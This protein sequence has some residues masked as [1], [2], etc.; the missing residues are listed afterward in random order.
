MTGE[1]EER[2]EDLQ[3]ESDTMEAQKGTIESKR[4]ELNQILAEAVS[5]GDLR[6]VRNALDNGADPDYRGISGNTLVGRACM[7]GYLGILK[8]LKKRK[9]DPTARMSGSAYSGYNAL[10]IARNRLNDH[11]EHPRSFLKTKARNNV[12]KF[13]EQWMEEVK[14][15]RIRNIGQELRG[16]T[17]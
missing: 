15:D 11:I 16:L 8:E 12:V 4:S 6:T 9:A 3:G 5:N 7:H 1:A 10:E 13:M 17:V 14:Q 2:E